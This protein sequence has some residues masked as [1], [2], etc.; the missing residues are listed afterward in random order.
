MKIFVNKNGSQSVGEKPVEIVER[1]GLGHPDTICDSVMNRV[2]VELSKNYI[3]EFGSV[4]HHNV[5]KCLLAAGK[6]IPAF[7]GGKVIEPMSLI[8]GDRATAIVEGKTVDVSGIANMAVDSWI[9]ENLRFVEPKH[10]VKSSKIQ[11]GS[12]ALQDIFHRGDSILGANDTSAV[13]GYSPLTDTEQLVLETEGWLNSK[14]FKK[15]SP[16][17]GEDIKLM[18]V[19]QNNH[20]DLTV[21][22]AF[23]DRYIKSENDYFTKKEELTNQI[24]EFIGSHF[25]YD[26]ATVKCNTLDVAG[27]GIDGI[28]LTVLGTS[29]DSADS[30]QVGRG[31]NIAGVIPLNRPSS[32]EAAAG[33][34]PNS[35]VGKIYNA[36]SFDIARSI[37][38]DL[39]YVTEANVWMTS[40]I[41]TYINNPHMVSVEIATKSGI[42]THEITPEVNEIIYKKLD[43]I[44]EFCDGLA[45]GTIS[46]Y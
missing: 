9:Q 6:T 7:E 29:A 38:S 30:G 11:P 1:K 44:N 46:T 31:N 27:R 8:M 42:P 35:H 17:I 25:T 33:K 13:F 37:T 10:L 36:L 43:N 40:R 14:D 19:R 28:Y 4:L 34:N 2:S 24:Y 3:K 23:V 5:D 26:S 12:I 18:A 20:V 15:S 21:A 41:G 16:E 32:A 45:K 22:T 39:S